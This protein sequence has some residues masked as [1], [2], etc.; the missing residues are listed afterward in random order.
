MAVESDKPVTET[1]R[2]LEVNT[3]TLHT[4]IARYHR[5][6][7]SSN[8]QVNDEHLYD[9]LKRLRKENARL[10]EERALL[11]KAVAF[12]ARKYH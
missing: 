3:G 2:E 9:E 10:K 12:F 1:A 6:E 4:W 11:K 8:P 5:P 7:A